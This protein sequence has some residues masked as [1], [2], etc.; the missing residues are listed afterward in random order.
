M[1]YLCFTD[2]E[3]QHTINLFLGL[4]VPDEGHPPIWELM[5]DYY[6]HH[7][8][9]KAIQQS[10]WWDASVIKCLPHAKNE[11]MK[12]CSEIIIVDQYDEMVDGYTDYY[13]P[14]EFTVMSSTHAYKISHSVR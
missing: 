3:K 6:L 9:K 13:K 12:H 5:T 7:G 4:F 8:N 14:Y 2:A 1:Q 10:Q 11:V